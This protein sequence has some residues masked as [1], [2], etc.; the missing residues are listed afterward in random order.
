[1]L[2]ITQVLLTCVLVVLVL[3]HSAKD[4]GLSG[5]FGVSSHTASSQLERNLT[6][7]TICCAL[8]WA[9]NIIALLKA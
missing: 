1:M 3:M 9:A 6:R 5:A 7:Y 8:L 4:T 2:T